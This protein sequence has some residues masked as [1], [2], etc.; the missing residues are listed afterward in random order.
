[1]TASLVR[2]GAIARRSATKARYVVIDDGPELAGQRQLWDVFRVLAAL[3]RYTLP[4]VDAW[5]IGT[6]AMTTVNALVAMALC[7]AVAVT[8]WTWRAFV[9][10]VPLALVALRVALAPFGYVFGRP[11]PTARQARAGPRKVRL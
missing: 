8:R 10:L 11:Q 3:D 6:L 7:S 5:P 4:L 1:V 2:S 9:F